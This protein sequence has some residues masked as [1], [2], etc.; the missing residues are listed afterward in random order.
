MTATRQFAL[1]H[2]LFAAALSLGLWTYTGS[3]HAG[4]YVGLDGSSLAIENSLDDELNPR[5]MRLRL[6]MPV[7]SMFD[8]EL[9]LGGGRDSETLV[10]DRFT[11]VYA[12]AFL[13]GY[14]PVGARSA[15]FG[16]AG[17]TSVDLTQ[18]IDGREFS[19]DRGSFSYGFG[20][21]TE[22]SERMDLSADYMNYVR[23]DGP[24]SEITA[25]N[26]GI[27]LYF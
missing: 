19:D 5:G 13:K 9:H 15:L 4:G 14:L 20:L 27:K 18:D 16:L 2:T 10:A 26:L 23:N 1:T 22:I 8:I 21:E 3:A 7:A 17:F 11:A 12:G 25:I 6:G 24:F